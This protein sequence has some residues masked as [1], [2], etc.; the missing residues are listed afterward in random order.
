MANRLSY[1]EIVGLQ[2]KNRVDE[3][4]DG[5]KNILGNQETLLAK[6]E[7]LAAKVSPDWTFTN[8]LQR[9]NEYLDKGEIYTGR[10]I[11]L[12][13][14]QKIEQKG[15]E[16]EKEEYYRLVV[17]SFLL[18][19]P[20]QKEAAPYYEKLLSHSTDPFR[21]ILRKITYKILT[22]DF[23]DAEKQLDFEL[24]LEHSQDDKDKLIEL[25][26]N[27]MNA[28]KKRDELN[29]YIESLNGI[30]GD[31]LIWEI[32]S[33]L[34]KSH[35]DEAK[36]L[37]NENY[38]YFSKDSFRIKKAKFEA[39]LSFYTSQWRNGVEIEKCFQELRALISFA[40]QLIE[41]SGERT[42]EK[43]SYLCQ[44]A[45]IYSDLGEIGKSEEIYN[46]AAQED[47]DNYLLLRNFP[48]LLIQFEEK[49]KH[50]YATD[51]LEKFLRIYE[52]EPLVRFH[53]Y[54]SLLLSDIDRAISELENFKEEFIEI[55]ILLV[56][57]YTKKFNTTKA[58]DILQKL[59]KKYPEN[60]LILYT[61]GYL[62]RILNDYDSALV[63]YEQAYKLGIEEP[64]KMMMLGEIVGI[65]LNKG[66]KYFFNK[67]IALLEE[68]Y[69]N[70][71]IVVNFPEKYTS[72]LI[73]VEKYTESLLVIRKIREL[74]SITSGLIRKEAFCFYAT[75]NF[76]L[77]I[78]GYTDIIEQ[79]EVTREDLYHLSQCYISLGESEKAREIIPRLPIPKNAD[80]F[81]SQAIF[82]LRIGDKQNAVKKIIQ[83]F[84]K[85]SHDQKIME[86]FITLVFSHNV[87]LTESEQKI[88]HQCLSDYEKSPFDRKVL[89][90]IKM[91]KE[92]SADKMD[93]LLTEAMKKFTGGREPINIEKSINVIQKSKLPISLL[94]RVMN[95][96]HLLLWNNTVKSVDQKIWTEH[97]DS[98]Y[99]L[100]VELPRSVYIDLTSIITLD[101][102][103]ILNDLL[104]IFDEIRITQSIL[105]ELLVLKAQQEEITGKIKEYEP[106]YTKCDRILSFFKNNTGIVKIVGQPLHN[107][108]PDSQIVELI[109]KNPE[110]RY[111]LEPIASSYKENLPAIISNS[112][113][114]QF[115]SKEEDSSSCIGI[116][117]I[118]IKIVLKNKWKQVL[119]YDFISE[120]I[121]LNYGYFKL[122]HIFFFYLIKK[123]GY[124]IDKRIEKIFSLLSDAFYNDQYIYKI[125]L[126][127]L[128]SIWLEVMSVDIKKKWHNFIIDILKNRMGYTLEI[129]TR[130]SLFLLQLV[131]NEES[132]I[133]LEELIEN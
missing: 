51:L 89:Y 116:Y 73:G 7:D 74:N 92:I 105:D 53:Y 101:H 114:R 83:G 3:L 27:V 61:K 35:Y 100:S 62:N 97:P 75:L 111:D 20:N 24:G 123:E 1:P 125:S 119:I 98:K 115:S 14:E 69:S 15:K 110:L 84:E 16:T 32:E 117:E 25:K 57:A 39:Y 120:L 34:Y 91:P 112:T 45:Y 127:L 6:M 79:G 86:L 23:K 38:D 10:D 130:L 108:R 71:F 12:S 40:D 58:K 5:Q 60:S 124:K 55:E 56:Q 33:L 118:I 99:D 18:D 90:S 122:D 59:E 113:I 41:E 48:L 29:L 36:K 46:L 67:A 52:S 87:A 68:S 66:E 21:K 76:E 82:S 30:F 129:G 95:L 2:T 13:L 102:L 133:A 80:D 72:A 54:N 47:P 11:A 132:R 126:L 17:K 107:N 128:G 26:L 85:Y 65:S 103:G 42:F 93:S 94:K 121:V 50:R 31:Y 44:K 22:D 9:I 131:K 88:F 4:H 70:D 96:N 37:I 64:Y 49:E 43:G 19:I 78:S 8:E 63:N 104:T 28:Q 77:A 106:I 109:K 81:F